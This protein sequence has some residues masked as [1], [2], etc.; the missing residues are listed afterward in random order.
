MILRIL[1]AVIS[2]H[3]V[4]RCP[5]VKYHIETW[6]ELKNN[7]LFSIYLKD[8]NFQQIINLEILI[9]MSLT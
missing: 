4:N 8:T 3:Y 1:F 2:I 6:T 9:E 7:K 5:K